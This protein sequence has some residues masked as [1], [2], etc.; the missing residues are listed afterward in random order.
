MHDMNHDYQ[1]TVHDAS[2]AIVG[3]AGKFPASEASG[4]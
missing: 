3:M 4:F 2:L 1:H